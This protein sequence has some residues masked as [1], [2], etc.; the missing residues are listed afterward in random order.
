MGVVRVAELQLFTDF[1]FVEASTTEN[2]QI[3]LLNHQF[4]SNYAGSNSITGQVKNIGDDTVESVKILATTYDGYRQVIEEDA[5]NGTV[6]DLKAGQISS[7]NLT[8]PKDKF[9]HVYDYDLSIQW[10][11]LEG[12]DHRVNDTKT[13]SEK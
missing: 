3:L 11:D 10:L 7:F 4:R 5:I 13:Y 8:A 9:G 6:G 12:Q 1:G 2:Q